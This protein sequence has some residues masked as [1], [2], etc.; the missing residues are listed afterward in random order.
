MA[1]PPP[2]DT[3]LLGATLRGT[4]GF[5]GLVVSD[6]YAISF[7]ELQHAVAATPAGAAALALAAGVN[8]ELPSV[9][10]YGAPLLAAAEAGE[11]TAELVDQAAA[12]V[13]RQKCELGL[14]D[15]GWSPVPD[16]TASPDLDPPA[17]SG[18]GP[19]PGRGVRDPAGQPGRRAPDRRGQ[20]GRGCRAAGR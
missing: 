1:C 5:D 20:P 15:P 13:L 16:A 8:V 17:Q 11:V 14:L 12:G 19:P 10:C 2:R 7:L 6:Y 9:R 18:P 3:R 4:L